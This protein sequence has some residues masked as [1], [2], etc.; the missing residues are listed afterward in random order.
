MAFRKDVQDRP[1]GPWSKEFRNRA[2]TVREKLGLSLNDFGER[3]DFSGSFVHGLLAGKPS[4]RMNSKHA[5]RVLQVVE[6]L[7]VQAGIR[8]VGSATI[9]RSAGE[10][11]LAALVRQINSLGF[12]VTLSQTR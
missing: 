4:H 6:G 1:N 12:S 7:E 3:L 9:H 8:S 5:D 2:V 10:V 11:D